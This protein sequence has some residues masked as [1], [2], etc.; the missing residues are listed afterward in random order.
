MSNATNGPA[1]YLALGDWNAV[2]Y[3]C[4]RKYKAGT[5]VRHWQGY[6]V[7]PK[8]WEA[9]Q[10]QDFVRGI[11]DTQIPPWTQPSPAPIFVA[12]CDP[13]AQSAICDYTICD[14]AICDY[15]SP[16]FDPQVDSGPPP[17]NYQPN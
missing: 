6:W 17:Y 13:N 12:L 2:C 3:V 16:S 15:V 7:C 10:P 4:G 5:M 14:C 11:K 9:R 8:D 1:D